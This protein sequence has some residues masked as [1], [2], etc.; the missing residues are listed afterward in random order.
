MVSIKST[1]TTPWWYWVVFIDVFLLL[2]SVAARHDVD[3]PQAWRFYSAFNLSKEMN[4]SVWW[5][6]MLLA[7]ISLLCYEFYTNKIKGFDRPWLS[8]A[9][10][11]FILSIDE[12][13]SFHERLPKLWLAGVL[14]PLI[15]FLALYPLIVFLKDIKN[16]K[17]GIYILSGFGLYASVLGQE[18]LE[19]AVEFPSWFLGIRIAL[20]EGSEL[21]GTFVILFGILALREPDTGI[22]FQKIIPGPQFNNFFRV[23]LWLG[24]LLHILACLI[25]LP[26]LND[27][28][29]RGNPGIF[30]PTIVDFI[31]SCFLF[32][33]A[34]ALHGPYRI[35][36]FVL[37]G[38]F[39]LS[40]MGSMY[41]LLYLV[42]MSRVLFPED[43]F[44]DGFQFVYVTQIISVVISLVI[45]GKST[46]I[47]DLLFIILLVGIFV[48]SFIYESLVYTYMLP[49][50]FSFIIGYFYYRLYNKA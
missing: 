46:T 2:I 30:Y 7:T 11:F 36:G 10:V 26:A 50:L 34:K 21:L 25:I 13:C 19:F 20:E 24:V 35:I 42:P 3:F 9:A 43:F 8:L 37:S 32:W 48:L 44:I 38:I 47:N 17:T 33:K 12:I 16:Q 29:Q 45:A 1:S 23:F 15:F 22:S 5:S 40:S 49:G 6:G 4:L 28:D 41:D 14:M 27:L 31:I 18:I 39:L